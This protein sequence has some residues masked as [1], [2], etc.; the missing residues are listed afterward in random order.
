MTKFK[1]LHYIVGD[2]D[3]AFKGFYDAMLSDQRLSVFFENDQQI[4]MLIEK[5]KMHFK[6]T[7]DMSQEVLQKSYIKLGEYH[8]D[9]RIPYVD[10]I[11]GSSMLEEYFLLHIP[12]IDSSREIMDDIFEYFK[13]MKAYTAK[14]YLNRM[15]NEDKKDIEEFFKY[16]CSEEDTSFCSSIAYDKIKWLKSLLDSIEE[17]KDV[18]FD[19]NEGILK[20]WLSETTSISLEKK[21]FLVDLEKRIMINTQ[22]LFYFLNKHEYLEI[23]P[24]YTSLLSIYKLTLML[25]N[26]LTVEYA[27]KVIENMKIDPLAGLFR[28]DIFIE[29][30][31][32]E[33]LFANRENNYTFSVAYL[34]LDNFKEVNDNFG[35][36]SGDKVI[37][38]LGSIIKNAIRGSDMGFRIGGDEFAIIFKNASNADAKKVCQK[39]KVEF[40]SFEFI[41]NENKVFNVGISMGIVQ[42]NSENKLD[43]ETLIIAVDKKLYEAKNN[44]RSQISY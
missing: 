11:K 27:N 26:A 4:K 39:I 13:V 9:I 21:A 31:K 1:Y 42:Y 37:E 7:L 23:L 2:I 24:L 14:G 12:L 32:K 19:E 6:T 41:F 22:N 29:L 28:K 15:I 35:H 33:I 36:Y 18:S 40:S 17:E 43:F 3:A 30:L 16:S 44:G 5:Q 34:D 25:N 38:K 10:F 20:I 8:Y